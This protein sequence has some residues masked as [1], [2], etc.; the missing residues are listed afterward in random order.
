MTFQRTRLTTIEEDWD[1]LWLVGCTHIS[2]DAEGIHVEYQTMREIEEDIII[3][4]MHSWQPTILSDTL[5]AMHSWLNAY[6]S[7]KPSLYVPLQPIPTEEYPTLYHKCPICDSVTRIDFN[8]CVVCGG[9][10]P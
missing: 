1:W 3:G 8:T 10:I 6:Y 7:Q 2:I 4:F 5:R 9:K